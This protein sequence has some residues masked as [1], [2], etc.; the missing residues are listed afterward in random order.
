MFNILQAELRSRCNPQISGIKLQELQHLISNANVC[1]IISK[2]K[3]K[4][5]KIVV[6]ND[7]NWPDAYAATFGN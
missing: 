2:I 5:P 3:G 4:I 1:I 7:H 6:K